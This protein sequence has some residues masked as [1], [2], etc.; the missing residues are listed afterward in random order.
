MTDAT[1]VC[2]SFNYTELFEVKTKQSEMCAKEAELAQRV[3]V[4]V[5]TNLGAYFLLNKMP[6]ISSLVDLL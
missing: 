3:Q 6:P 5:E 1:I 4:L 2:M